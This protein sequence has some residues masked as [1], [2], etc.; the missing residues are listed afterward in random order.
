MRAPQ[1]VPDRAR[2]ALNALRTGED[3]DRNVHDG[4]RALHLRGKVH[5]PRGVHEKEL[6]AAEHKLRLIG[7]DGDPPRALQRVRVQEGVLVVDPAH[8]PDA[9]RVVEQRL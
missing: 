8:R 6:P 1:Q 7:E 4:D 9:V 2:V 3:Q 5:V